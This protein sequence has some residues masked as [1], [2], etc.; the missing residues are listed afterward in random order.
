MES[1]DIGII[2]SG[3]AGTFAALRVSEKYKDVRTIVFDIGRPPA[4]RRRPLE[5]FLG[6]FPTGN[7]RIYPN[8]LESINKFV[9][10]RKIN[11]SNQWVMEYFNQVNSMKLLKDKLPTKSLSKKLMTHD[12]DITPN[13]YYQWR[14]ESV[15][16]LSRLITS[17]LEASTNVFFSFD[18]QVTAIRQ[19][20]GLFS[21]E[22]EEGTV[23]CKK[24]IL[25][26]GRSGWR[27]VTDFYKELG[28]ITDNNSAKYGVRIE[29]P[30]QYAKELNK[31]SCVLNRK[32][33]E[34]GPFCWNGSVV[35][36]DH[37]DLVLSSFRSNEDRW[38]TEKLS[39]SVLKSMPYEN[40]GVAQTERIGKLTFLLYNDRVNKERIKSFMKGNSLISL[41]P[42]YYWLKQF[43]NEFEELLPVLIDY[44]HIHLPHIYP[45]AASI[46][47]DHGL[48]SD[49]PGLFV[50][51]ESANISGILGAAVSGCIAANEACK[52]IAG[53][54]VSDKIP[55]IPVVLGSHK[56]SDR[57][58]PVKVKDFL[59]RNCIK[60]NKPVPIKICAKEFN[61]PIS[62]F[63]R[64]FAKLLDLKS[65]SN[66]G[67][68]RGRSGGVFKR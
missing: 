48:Q 47:L 2:G 38:E 31:S 49:L 22:S 1:Y 34:I 23:E 30:A 11:S 60:G 62:K 17:S 45:M 54:V 63:R 7:G 44:G 56:D 36:E 14:P 32:D 20:E 68:C 6:C 27:W 40:Q 13:D 10:K 59:N 39:F 42:E 28:L 9:D 52:I 15:H 16:K 50:A 51:G 5:G 33:L 57:I 29:I 26:A 67:I 61:I 55:S 24:I 37:A 64:L 66:F 43:I 19:E 41:L 21:I 12:F 3:I 18:N 58:E 25:C 35:P 65:F 8:N 53:D 46:N 4:K